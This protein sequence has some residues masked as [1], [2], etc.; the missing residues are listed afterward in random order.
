[1][2]KHLRANLWLLLLSVALCS[3]VYPAI[4]WGIGQALFPER[5]NGSI[6]FDKQKKPVGSRLICQPFTKDE[7]FQPRPSAASYNGAASAAS[8]WGANN[9]LLRN[10]VVRQIGPL[11]RYGSGAKARQPAGPDIEDWFQKD[12][13]QGHPGI[14]AQWAQTHSGLAQGWVKADAMNGEWVNAWRKEHPD[15]VARWI[16]DNPDTAEPK[17]EDLATLFFTSYSKAHPGTFP[18]AVERKT[19]DGKVEKRIDPVKEGADIQGIFF[20]M[21]RQD[22]PEVDLEPVP[23]DMVLAS[24]SGL[25]PHITLKSALYQLSR[26]AAAWSEKT[27]KDEAQL[28]KEIQTLLEEKAEAPLGGLAGVKLINVLEINLALRDRYESPEERK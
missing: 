1:M 9:Y 5:A 28:E 6:I 10:R 17:P 26:V 12:R 2:Y 27:R 4:L 13:F 7:Y 16:Q 21:W 3:V 22:H 11:V 25:D 15:E 20:D 14:V 18:G 24:G 8:N 19:N 23:A